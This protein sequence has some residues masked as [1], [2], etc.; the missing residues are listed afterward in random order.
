M[1]YK[2]YIEFLK[3]SRELSNRFNRNNLKI[4]I[5]LVRTLF[6]KQRDFFKLFRVL[7]IDL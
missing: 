7:T 5:K 4:K 1:R 2:I 3:R 6:T